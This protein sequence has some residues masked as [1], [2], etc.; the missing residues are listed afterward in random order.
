[1][2]APPLATETET[3]IE[4]EEM[5]SEGDPLVASLSG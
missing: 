5:N 1:L 3:E 2:A 4:A